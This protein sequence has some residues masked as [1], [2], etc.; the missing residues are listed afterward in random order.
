MNDLEKKYYD[1]LVS[2]NAKYNLTNI[3]DMDEAMCKHFCDSYKLGEAFDLSKDISLCDVGSGAGFPSIALKLKYPN[4]KVTII[5]AMKKRCDFL[6]NLVKILELKDVT[7]ICDRAENLKDLKESF[8]IVTARAVAS[9]PI[10]IEV[11]SQFA[12]VGGFFAP[13][14]GSNYQEEIDLTHNATKILGYKLDGIYKYDLIDKNG[15]DYG[16]RAIIKYKKIKSTDNKYPRLYSQ[17]KKKNL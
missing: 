7:I 15:N 2:E 6:E 10:L 14:K 1:F 3:T 16:S 12:K 9:L 17:I 4:I 11:C 8:D 5:E 13:F